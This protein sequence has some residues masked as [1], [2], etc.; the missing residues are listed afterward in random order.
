MK[1]LYYEQLIETRFFIAFPF[2]RSSQDT[3]VNAGLAVTVTEHFKFTKEFQV[4]DTQLHLS[5]AF[6]IRPNNIL[7]SA[8]IT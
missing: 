2:N 8:V 7:T 3:L 1:Y 4:L 5:F 6:S